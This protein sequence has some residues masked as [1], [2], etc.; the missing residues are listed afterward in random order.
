METNKYFMKKFFYFIAG[1][2]FVAL[3]SATTVSVMTI[4]PANPKLVIVKFIKND[5]VESEIISYYKKGFILKSAS[6]VG[7]SGA[8]TLITMEKY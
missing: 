7:T 3:I 5:D 4:K 1:V 8:T 6:T 2:L